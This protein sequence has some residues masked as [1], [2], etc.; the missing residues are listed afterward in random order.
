M[1]AI[2]ETA[3]PRFKYSLTKPEICSLYTPTDTEHKWMRGRRVDSQLQHAHMIYL[4]CFQRVGYF[5]AFSDIPRS[6]RE[7]IA[8]SIN[9]DPISLAYIEAIPGRTLRRLK[10]SV[11]RRCGVKRFMLQSEGDWLRDFAFNIAQTKESV[12]DVINAMIE[13]LV[14]ESY[15]LPAFSTL[16]RLGYE[17]RSAANDHH[18][19]RISE[20]LSPRAIRCLE[21]ILSE[22]DDSGTTLWHRLKEEPKK[23]TISGFEQFYEHAKWLRGQADIL[24]PL[25]ELPEAKINQMVLEAKAYTRDRMSSM[26]RSKRLALAACLVSLQAQYCT[27]CIVDLFIRE[28]R[29]IHNRA[30]ADLAKFQSA[31]ISES[32]Q[33]ISI[34]F[35]VAKVMSHEGSEE[36]QIQQI[37][38]A[39]DNDPETIA[40]RCDRLIHHGLTSHLPFLKRRYSGKTRRTL[41]KCLSLFEI[42]H[43]AYGGDLLACLRIV[44]QYRDK[45]LATLSVDAIDSPRGAGQT[46]IDWI[47]NQW[48]SVLYQDQRP[49]KINRTMDA[50]IFELAVLT[51]ISKRFQSGDLFVDNSTKYDDYRKHL[52]SWEHYNATVSAFTRQIGLSKSPV[53]FTKRLKR[54]FTTTAS[55]ADERFPKDGFVEFAADH[56]HLRRRKSPETPEAIKRLDAAIADALP[57]V[58]ILDLLVETTQ[59]VDLHKSFR[60]VSG[61]Q[62]KSAP[63]L[64][65]SLSSK[66]VT[67]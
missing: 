51:E 52:I 58:N 10:T 15:E 13:L 1:A 21:S 27:D 66:A 6:I 20:S 64:A 37:S 61:H 36:E 55:K 8:E 65:Y 35:N 67:G 19:N 11:R 48:S 2:H 25:P 63:G 33:L 56:I 14:K 45:N 42:D 16:D 31:S 54:N 26:R 18:F 53:V 22:S 57:Q 30:K 50:K 44:I 34:L 4:K 7:H 59:W 24:G 17:A 23:P 5:P 28:I 9:R 43:T 32:E 38:Q 60:P 40:L 3:Y 47:G 39:L 12:I 62:T 46:A 29:R 49:N 41:L